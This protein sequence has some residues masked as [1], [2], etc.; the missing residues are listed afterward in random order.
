MGGGS[1]QVNPPH[2]VS[3]ADGLGDV[4]GER[5]SVVDGV[6]VRERP[7]AADPD[8][9][10]DPETGEPGVRVRFYDAAGELMAQQHSSVASVSIGWDDALPRPVH[11]V[12]L[13]ARIDGHGPTRLGALGVGAWT[14]A[15]DGVEVASTTLAAEGHDPGE[16]MLKP[17]PGRTRSR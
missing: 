12:T 8:A 10:R 1:A 13:S 16:S 2:Q 17:R 7:V 14:L 3:I 5:L 15:V 9:V 6:E 4:L 11:R